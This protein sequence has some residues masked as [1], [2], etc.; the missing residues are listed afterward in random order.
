MDSIR[1]KVTEVNCSGP[2]SPILIYD[3]GNI[4]VEHDPQYPEHLSFEFLGIEMGPT[5]D[6]SACYFIRESA[7]GNT[8]GKCYKIEYWQKNECDS[9]YAFSYFQVDDQCPL[10]TQSISVSDTVVCAGDC[11]SFSTGSF[12]PISY[13]WSFPG[14]TPDTSS[15]QNPQNICY[16]TPGLYPVTLI[17][18]NCFNRDTI[19]KTDYIQVLPAPLPNGPAQNETVLILGDSAILEACAT[20]DSYAWSPPT[21]LSCTDCP[22]PVASPAASTTYTLL[23]NADG[24]CTDTCTYSVL[25]GT[26]PIAG[27]SP[28]QS[29]ICEDECVGFSFTGSGPVDSYSWHFPGGEPATS[30]GAAPQ[31][32][33]YPAAGSYPVLLVVQ[34]AFGADSLLVE[35]FVTVTPQV[36]LTGEAVQP[37]SL[38]FGDTVQLTACATG[39]SYAWSPPD[40]LSCTD[41]PAPVLV[42]TVSA[43]YTLEVSNGG[44]V[45]AATCEY[46]VTVSFDERIYLP[47]AFSPNADGI[48]DVF[49]AYG[50]HHRVESL[51]IFHRWGGM[52]YD[53]RGET[54]A[55][56]GTSKGLPAQPG[57]YVYLLHYTDTRTGE[58]EMKSGEVVLVR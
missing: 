57:V 22:S 27:F 26:P 8:I 24:P 20:G 1:V 39:G 40:G 55:W 19:T 21:G 25:V 12:W 2:E 46:P 43:S 51:Q 9:T 45:C 52:A 41:C 56:D 44:A 16:P 10:I 5:G 7:L 35:N 3:S 42:A 18:E 36:E 33:C 47:N 29:A 28:A 37:F 17:Y 54:A 6:E 58:M 50:K 30:T 53:G 38:A 34:N 13:A 15:E 32:I 31:G 48:N 4:F 23:V 14:A 11:I 49:T